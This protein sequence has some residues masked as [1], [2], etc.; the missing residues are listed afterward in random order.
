MAK[1]LRPA[2]IASTVSDDNIPF[3]MRPRSGGD[4]ASFVI[5]GPQ[6]FEHTVHVSRDSELG[7]QNM[8]EWMA[9]QLA[10]SGIQ[11][12]DVLQHPKEVLQVVNF[13]NQRNTPA[14]PPPPAAAAP[15]PTVR[16][17]APAKPSAAP[18]PARSPPSPATA[19]L[20]FEPMHPRDI[21][22]D[23]TQVGSG[24]TSTV[25][26][27]RTMAT[28]K[29]VAVKAINLAEQDR[30]VI[31]NQVQLQHQLKHSN[32]VQIERA[33]L[34]DNW[35]YIVMEYMDGGKLTDILTMCN[36]TESHIAFFLREVLAGLTL[37]HDS[38]KIHRDIKSDNVLVSTAGE[39]KLTG[40]GY[41]AQL[42]NAA[43]R[44]KTICGTPY[45]MAPELIQGLPYGKE[46]DIWSLGIMAIE[47]AEGAPPYFQEVPGRALYLIVLQGVPGLTSKG[48][49]SPEFN[50]F[51]DRC[52]AREPG[53][54]PSAADLAK[55]PFIRKACRTIDIVTLQQFAAAEKARER[56]T[57]F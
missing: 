48:D 15:S 39:V 29:L 49:W 26:R 21:I 36:C 42:S 34:H 5:T 17:K 51:V 20:P 38:D 7:F 57:S 28:G 9:K 43:D 16:S 53:G 10:S 25:F 40:F 33:L 30:D 3:D 52:L 2:Q 47:L 8:P 22:A 31:E 54:R 37:L 4:D 12:G 55:H 13:L 46:V 50:D 14:A 27:G 18:P 41:T 56:G 32:I 23:L 24:G 45:W 1:H 19:K 11:K 6:S 35:L 44:R